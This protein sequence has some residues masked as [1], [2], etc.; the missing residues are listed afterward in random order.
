MLRR[1]HASRRGRATAA[2]AAAG[3]AS[4]LLGASAALAPGAASAQADDEADVRARLRYEAGTNLYRAG[5]FAGA[6]REYEAA[7][8]L[9]GRPNLLYNLYVAWRDAGELRKAAD[10]LERYLDA[11]PDAEDRVNLEARLA[12]MQQQIAALDAAEAARRAEAPTEPAPEDGSEETREAEP[13]GDDEGGGGPGVVPWVVGGVGVAAIVAGAITGGMALGLESD[14]EGACPGNVCPADRAD[15]V[16]R[17]STLATTTDVL[18]IGGAALVATGVVL[19]F[20]LPRDG[21]E[22][23]EAVALRPTGGCGPHGCLVGVRGSFR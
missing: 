19:Y 16:D 22:G 2:L 13:A 17:L 12:A 5:D 1:T 21:D 14:L 10:A 20:V 7:Y 9:S 18:L 11:V 6:A 15:D 4:A 23:G 8:E 3:L